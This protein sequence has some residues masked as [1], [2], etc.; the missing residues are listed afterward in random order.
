MSVFE[1]S[2]YRFFIIYFMNF[3]G[4]LGILK[5]FFLELIFIFIV[6]FYNMFCFYI[7]L[8]FWVLG[9][10]LVFYVIFSI[11]YSVW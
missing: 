11:E 2:K 4:F 7:R 8:R 5:R 10:C 3:G 9:L 6:L 1:F